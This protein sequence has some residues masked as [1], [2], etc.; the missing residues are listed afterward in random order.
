MRGFRALPGDFPDR[1]D[2]RIQLSSIIFPKV[3]S[4]LTLSKEKV[5]KAD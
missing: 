5:R 4:A 3:F 1:R 2:T